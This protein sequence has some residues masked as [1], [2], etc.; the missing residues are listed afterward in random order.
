MATARSTVCS[1]S[2]SSASR[3]GVELPHEGPYETVAGF[4]MSEIGRVARV[5]DV[6]DY[7]QYR[8]TVA[9]LDGRR[10]AASA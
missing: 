7:Q 8:L 9:E 6:V 2:A 1:T 4:V 3:S 5:G 10:I